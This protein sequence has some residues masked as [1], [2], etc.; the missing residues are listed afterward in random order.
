MG[1]VNRTSCLHTNP[2][3]VRAHFPWLT[4]HGNKN[5][6]RGSHHQPIQM[7]ATSFEVAD[8]YVNPQCFSPAQPLTH[9]QKQD[10]SKGGPVMLDDCFFYSLQPLEVFHPYSRSSQFWFVN[11]LLRGFWWMVLGH[12]DLRRAGHGNHT[13]PSVTK[14]AH[15]PKVWAVTVM[16]PSHCAFV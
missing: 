3:S 12:G 16:T 5:P 4:L 6:T 10:S 15:P 11:M 13:K 1:P 8:C 9:S 14:L 2:S 7:S